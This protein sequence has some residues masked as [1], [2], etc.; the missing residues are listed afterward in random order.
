MEKFLVVIVGG[1]SIYILEIILMLLDNLDRL[2]LRVIKLY[3]NDEE[4]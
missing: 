1:G 4:R 3:D 2:L